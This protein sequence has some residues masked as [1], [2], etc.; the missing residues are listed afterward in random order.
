MTKTTKPILKENKSYT[1][2]DYFELN[3]PTRD[4]V[5]EFGYS[6]ELKCLD[7]PSKA[8][9]GNLDYLK[10]TYYQRLPH[11]SL[12]SE[13]AKREVLIAPLL[14]EL[15]D[16]INID[17]DI[18]YPLNVSEKLKGNIDYFITSSHSFI[19]IEAKKSDMEKGFTQLAVELIA[20]DK[21]IDA[22]K[23]NIY[24]ALTIGDLWRFGVLNC[25][26]KAIYRDIDSFRVPADLD[27][28]FSVLIGILT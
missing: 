16:H 5:A 2:S 11:V 13:A 8:F 9:E 22:E 20:V 21:F 25:R 14:L 27:K 7:L 1:F 15:L 4:I 3:Y 12:T 26:E 18:E 19:V 10:K 23:E 6:Y 17:I 24:G 28:L